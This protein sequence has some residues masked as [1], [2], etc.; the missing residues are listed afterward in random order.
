MDSDVVKSLVQLI[1]FIDNAEES[2]SV[3]NE[4]VAF[5]C[6]NLLDF[7]VQQSKDI[8]DVSKT[9]SQVKDALLKLTSEDLSDEIDNV[10]EVL[11]FLKGIKDDET[12]LAKIS[13][14]FTEIRTLDTTITG[15]LADKVD[16]ELGKG[17]SSND[18]TNAE[19]NKLAGIEEG[20]NKYVHPATHPATMI[21]ED[22][23]HRF[24]TDAERE[25]LDGVADGANKYVHP[26]THPATMIEEDAEHRFVSDAE[27]QKWNELLDKD[28]LTPWQK[29]YLENLEDQEVRKKFAVA[30]S[31]APASKE[32]DGAA[33]AVRLTVRPTYDGKGV[34][35]VVTGKDGV[36]F[37]GSGGVYT[38]DVVWAVPAETKGT[39]S[40]SWGA[41]VEYNL[42]GTV[43]SKDVSAAVGLYAQCRVLQTAGTDAPA[44]E[45]IKSAVMKRRGITGSYDITVVPGQYVW[46]CVPDGLT[47]VSGVTS[48]GFGVPLEPPVSVTVAWG[49]SRVLFRC[50]RVSGAPQSSPMRV[51]VS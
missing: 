2:A 1:N 10:E 20:A 34:D 17:L 27:K 47:G 29:A 9:A 44:A 49:A 3:T 42:N 14:I 19:K 32:I 41:V 21:R 5:I 36:V 31:A 43:L 48:S 37:S 26:A 7:I 11:N 18:Y 39:Y 6:R 25:K 35:A 15:E 38:A 8:N 12:L 50:W 51:V 30:M 28:A 45:A 24:V 4:H 33:T 13:E 22:A 46:L 40:R 16:K 23:E